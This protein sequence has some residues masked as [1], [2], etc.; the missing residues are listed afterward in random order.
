MQT[1]EAILSL[2]TLLSLSS[3]AFV[4]SSMGVDDSLYVQELTGDVRNVIH[5]KGGDADPAAFALASEEIRSEAGL[6][7]E[8]PLS[9]PYSNLPPPA[10]EY[11]V[12]SSPILAPVFSPLT[13][14]VNGSQ[15][16][17]GPLNLTGFTQGDMRVWSCP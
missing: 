6:C 11:M 14:F 9:P 4:S 3:L 12:H 7:V 10:Y 15:V 5:E 2:L 8:S 13:A 16:D 17:L 1:L